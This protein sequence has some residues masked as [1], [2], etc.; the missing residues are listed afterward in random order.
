MRA[1]NMAL[2]K[3]TPI[4][5]FFPANDQIYIRSPSELGPGR[6]EDPD[7]ILLFAWGDGLPKHVAKY[8]EGFHKLYPAAEQIIVLGPI[9]KVF[10]ATLKTRVA[11]MKP[12]LDALSD[13]VSPAAATKSSILVHCMSNTGGSNYASM[14]HAYRDKY[15]VPFPHDLVVFDSTPGSPELSWKRLGQWSRAMSM[16]IAKFFP[17]PEIVTRCIM[18]LATICVYV[19]GLLSGE[20]PAGKFAVRVLD[21]ETYIAKSVKRAYLYSKADDLISSEDVEMYIADA[22]QKGY[23]TMAEVFDGSPHVGHMR[24]HPDQYWAA[25]RKAWDWVKASPASN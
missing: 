24:L 11:D 17:W 25:I 14:L 21:D 4:P 23:E 15:G 2:K 10:F 12:V 18:G 3:I 19:I 20:E 5:N 6:A 16:G 22:K 13:T 7:V 1:A 8:A 9:S